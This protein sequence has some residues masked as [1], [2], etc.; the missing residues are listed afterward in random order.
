M[1]NFPPYKEIETQ[2]PLTQKD[3]KRVNDDNTENRKN[4]DKITTKNRESTCTGL[5]L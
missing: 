5:S 2:T 4:P 1:C 3:S